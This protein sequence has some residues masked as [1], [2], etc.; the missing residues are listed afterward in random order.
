MD[1]I[2]EFDNLNDDIFNQIKECIGKLDLTFQHSLLYDSAAK[3]KLLD[4]SKRKSEF[5]LIK[6]KTLFDLFDQLVD[7]VNRKVKESNFQL[8]KNDVMYIR[9]K[10]GDFFEPHTDFLTYKT[11]M[12]KEHTMIL[13]LDA[14]CVG[15]ETVFHINPYFKHKC[16]NT[17]EPGKSVVFRKDFYHE[18]SMIKSGHKHILVV[19]L[20]EINEKVEGCLA[21]KFRDETHDP[22]IIPISNVFAFPNKLQKHIDRTSKDKIHIYECEYEYDV[23]KVIYHI[24]MRHHI[25][26]EDYSKAIFLINELNI[27]FENM[28]VDAEYMNLDS[29]NVESIESETDNEA[30]SSLDDSSLDEDE[31][32]EILS[33]IKNKSSH[34]KKIKNK[35]QILLF[36][37]KD[38]MDFY[39]QTI[40]KPQKLN[41]IPF[42]LVFAEGQS[43]VDDCGIEIIK[44]VIMETIGEM[45]YLGTASKL[46]SMNSFREENN[47]SED[48][49]CDVMYFD[50]DDDCLQGDEQN[51]LQTHFYDFKVFMGSKYFTDTE[52]FNYLNKKNE[53]TPGCNY[54]NIMDDY[55]FENGEELEFITID[56]KSG[57]FG[58]NE[59]QLEYIKEYWPSVKKK[60]ENKLSNAE[61]NFPQILSHS[62]SG[63]LCNETFYGE[64]T[65]VRISGL[66]RIE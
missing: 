50:E 10:E 47:Y 9:Y 26:M 51:L 17:I 66:W 8:V 12:F 5:A 40:I 41:Y 39:Y 15:G 55:D 52:L 13:C 30:N 44:S 62:D 31:K 11:N 53:V 24:L 61:I 20:L 56:K 22:L 14:D 35:E 33:K 38:E 65:L 59:K 28:I 34:V 27:R 45:E 21:I 1:T 23:M 54:E 25:T 18:G 57:R 6:E 37:D 42:M 19:N 60:I 48:K 58:F 49:G 63:S 7:E 16:S 4:K 64:F 46:H 2:K 29:D 3:E 43:C 32:E 36:S